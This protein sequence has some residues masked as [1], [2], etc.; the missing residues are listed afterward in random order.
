MPSLEMRVLKKNHDRPTSD[1]RRRVTIVLTVL[2]SLIAVDL[3]VRASATGLAPYRWDP[4]RRKL[5]ALTAQSPKPEIVLIGS[6]RVKHGLDPEVFHSLTGKRAFNAGLAATKVL[7]WQCV[8]E[9]YIRDVHP[10]LVILGVNVSAFRD[11]YLPIPAARNLFTWDDVVH[12]CRTDG[13]SGQVVGD[14]LIHN[15]EH[16]WATFHHREEIRLIL[17]GKLDRILP[18]YA[19]QS[20]DRRKQVAKSCPDN[21]YEHPW[22][23]S[24]IMPDL[25]QQLDQQ[26]ERV[27]RASTPV[28]S[29]NA[30]AFRHFESLLDWFDNQGIPLIIAYIPNSPRTEARWTAV[31]PDMIHVLETV[32]NKHDVPFISCDQDELPRENR[33]YMEELHVGLPLARRISERIARTA[34]TLG[35]FKAGENHLAQSTEFERHLP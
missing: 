11:D 19:Q 18:K 8:A 34:M 10:D 1:H 32:C 7:E 21:G 26:G 17:Q 31:E 4:Y 20:R 2:A 15:S 33:D 35:L 25:Q 27:W 30:P 12:Y 3:L 16:V 23:S 5:D 24:T 22:L 9:D 14:F 28:F 13:W 6:S 29:P